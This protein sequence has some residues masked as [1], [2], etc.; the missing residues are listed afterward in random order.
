MSSFQCGDSVCGTGDWSGPAPGDPDSFSLLTATPA[1]GG[2]DVN[3]SYPGINPHAVAHSIVY[4]STAAQQETAARHVVVDGNFFYDKTTTVTPVQY[5][6]WIQLVSVNGTYSQLIGPA[7]AQARPTIQDVLAQLSEQI[8]AGMLSQTL[9]QDIAQI[10]LNTLN[11][12]REMIDRAQ[13]DNALG[14]AFNEVQAFSEGTRALVQEEVVA[15]T[16]ANSAIVNTVN[17]LYAGMDQRIASVQQTSQALV[18]ESQAQAESLTTVQADLYGNVASGQ[19]GIKASVQTLESGV[20]EIG[21]LY[22]ATVDVNGLVGGFG[23]YNNG[24][25]VE[26]GFNVDTFWVGKASSKIKPFIVSGSEVFIDQAVINQ[27]TFT[28]L[29]DEAGTVMVEGGKLKA[30]YLELDFASVSG[31]L[32]SSNYR[33]RSGSTPGLG[34][35][36][37]RAGTFQNYGE[38]VGEGS[39]DQNNQNITVYD[40]N[41]IKRVQMGRLI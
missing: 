27:L 28:K 12:T 22:T 41:N 2:I 16:T 9:K 8:D 34:W 11:I 18:D 20:T 10:Q 1:F 15:R 40:A 5:Y 39:M 21:A 37:D 14:V 3:W 13:G 29:R 17:T 30:K 4:R 6:Y 33:A 26:A 24:Q 23:V 31:A 36:L 35:K 7:T 38:V 25:R 32:Q 19:V